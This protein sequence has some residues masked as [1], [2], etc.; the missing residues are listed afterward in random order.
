VP[1]LETAQL[2]SGDGTRVGYRTLGDGPPLIIAH[3]EFSTSDDYI[4]LA[5]RL[6][7]SHRVILVDRRGYRSSE[8]GPSPATFAQDAE[9]LVCLMATLGPRC[10]V[11]GHS[12]GALV[13]LHAARAAPGSI[14]AL[15]LYEP[16][17]LFA[18]AARQPLLDR[19]RQLRAA[20]EDGAALVAFTS[21]TSAVPEDVVRRWVDAPGLTPRL[22]GVAIGVGRDLE[23]VVAFRPEFE[24]WRALLVPVTLLL[25]SE[26]RDDPLADSV[27]GLAAVLPRSRVVA[28]PDQEHVAHV[29]DPAVLAEAIRDALA[30]AL[31]G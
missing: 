16:P 14:G 17:V 25:G 3:S 22:S 28:L 31:Q 21:A 9:D 30:D 12:A 1:V 2:T 15:A 27:R 13:A 18:G 5:V 7:S 29:L 8:V 4:P 26:S 6:A 24:P 20:G 10:A 19:Y 11:F 23:A